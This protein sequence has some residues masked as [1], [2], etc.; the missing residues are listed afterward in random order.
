[1]MSPRP[2]G[3]DVPAW[4]CDDPQRR[5]VIPEII[6]VER[7]AV[8]IRHHVSERTLASFAASADRN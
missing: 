6:T 8:G 4:V 3:I 7:D 2:E 5:M 1:M